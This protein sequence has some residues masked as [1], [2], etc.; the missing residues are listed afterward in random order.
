MWYAQLGWYICLAQH[1]ITN[2]GLIH[3]QII[4]NMW[5]QTP[6]Y[7]GSAF[8]HRT[9]TAVRRVPTSRQTL[10][11]SARVP[12]QHTHLAILQQ[13]SHTAL[14][15]EHNLDVYMHQLYVCVSERK[16]L[17]D[18]TWLIRSRPHA[19]AMNCVVGEETSRCP[20][21]HQAHDHLLKLF[22]WLTTTTSLLERD[23]PQNVGQSGSDW[24]GST[25]IL[26][27]LLV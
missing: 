11:P 16:S 24:S 20:H 6:F 17:T 21:S 25:S 19:R 9:I 27:D 22:C 7:I 26:F 4:T 1:T 18:L 12:H 3:S 2:N 5:T 23:R 13:R 8:I 14:P 15:P 10:S